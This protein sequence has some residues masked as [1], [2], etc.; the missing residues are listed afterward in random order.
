MTAKLTLRYEFGS[1]PNDDF[2]WLALAVETDRFTGRGRFS[3]QWQDVT[4][5]AP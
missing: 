4:E 1:D 2:G 3:V 5:M